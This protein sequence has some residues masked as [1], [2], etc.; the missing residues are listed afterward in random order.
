MIPADV[1]HI[2]FT[3]VAMR[4]SAVPYKMTVMHA[5]SKAMEVQPS[6]NISTEG[7]VPT[8]T[9]KFRLFFPCTGLVAEQVE[10]LLQ[11][12][13]VTSP[14][15]H[16]NGEESVLNSFKQIRFRCLLQFVLYSFEFHLEVWNELNEFQDNINI[17]PTLTVK[18]SRSSNI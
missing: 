5:P 16:C 9:S 10:T 12:K 2:D 8:K 15:S 4:G 11:V 13:L 18:T 6:V 17:L 1:D 14:V 3:W 7:I